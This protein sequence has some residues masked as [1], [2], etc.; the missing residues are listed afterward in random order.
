MWSC[1]AGLECIKLPTCMHQNLIKLLFSVQGHTWLACK[2]Q[3]NDYPNIVSSICLGPFPAKMCSFH[4][5][6]ECTKLRLWMLRMHQKLVR[7]LFSSVFVHNES[8]SKM[9]WSIYL[10][11]FL[12][13][14][15]SSSPGLWFSKLP[16]LVRWMQPQ[17]VNFLFSVHNWFVKVQANSHP[18][19]VWS[20]Y[21]DFFGW[22]VVMFCRVRM[23]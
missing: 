10:G 23:H 11:P 14:M 12:A 4:A 15:C 8:F 9:F 7:L 21:L 2:N 3:E 18:N 16:L 6:L 13:E 1:F 22:N 5:G 20:I 17:L 19:I